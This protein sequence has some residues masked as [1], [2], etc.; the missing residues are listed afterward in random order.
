MLR[1]AARQFETV[2]LDIA[3]KSMRATVPTDGATD[4]ESTRMFTGLLDQQF[5]QGIAKQG[6][7]GLADV[8]VKQLSRLRAGH[9]QEMAAAADS[10]AGEAQ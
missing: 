6:G 5:V 9:G 7:L 1:E 2:L 10:K 8:L 4:S 3:M